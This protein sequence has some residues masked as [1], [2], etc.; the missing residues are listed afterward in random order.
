MVVRHFLLRG[1]LFPWQ[2]VA[3]R[4]RASSKLQGDRV[5]QCLGKSRRTRP[6][7]RWL[8]CR[9][10]A[11]RPSTANLWDVGQFAKDFAWHQ[12]PTVTV[13]PD[14]FC[15]MSI[16]NLLLEPLPSAV[17]DLAGGC[18]L[19]GGV[20][21]KVMLGQYMIPPLTYAE[22]TTSFPS[23]SRTAQTSSGLSALS[24]DQGVVPYCSFIV[25]TPQPADAPPP[26]T[27]AT[28]GAPIPMTNREQPNRML[29][30]TPQDIGISGDYPGGFKSIPFTY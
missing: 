26:T 3:M 24:V 28:L 5:Y 6:C 10:C 30:L 27:A 18:G 17:V 25:N 22:S 15:G 11:P 21:N 14:L 19:N 16:K 9:N 20:K 1:R 12:S 4:H 13:D 8:R 23:A 7:S 2:V 29:R